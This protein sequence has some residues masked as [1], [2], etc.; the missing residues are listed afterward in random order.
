MSQVEH[1][2]HALARGGVRERRAR[3]GTRRAAAAIEYCLLLSLVAVGFIGVVQHVGLESLDVFNSVTS[4]MRNETGS[5][6]G[7]DEGDDDGEDEDEGK[8]DDKTCKHR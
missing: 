8:K 4:M 7:E 3:R 5:D 1:E 6:E 2:G